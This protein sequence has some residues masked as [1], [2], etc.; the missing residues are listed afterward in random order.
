MTTSIL[1]HRADSGRDREAIEAALSRLGWSV[2]WKRKGEFIATKGDRKLTL[3][4]PTL[5]AGLDGHSID[6]LPAEELALLLADLLAL[7]IPDPLTESI[8]LCR[9]LLRPRLITPTDLEGPARSMCRRPAWGTLSWGVSIGLRSRRS[10]VTSRMLDQWGLEFQD[11]M[12]IATENLRPAFSPDLVCEVGDIDGLF[13]IMH[14]REPAASALL[15]LDE[16]VPPTEDLPFHGHVFSTPSEA[17]LLVM[18]VPEG[19]GADALA[20]LVQATFAI[21][22]EHS[23]SL[24]DQVFWRRRDRITTLP[25]TWVEEQGTRRVHLEAEGDIGELLRILGEID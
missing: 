15:L 13:A 25:M 2:S 21:A 20:S 17:T 19:A 18:P 4:L 10:F 22:A 14:D 7:S 23:P 1:H 8:D 16:L 9:P 12:L 3:E 5:L 11:L 24:S 6:K